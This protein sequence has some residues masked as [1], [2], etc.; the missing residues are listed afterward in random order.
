MD[1]KQMA[2]QALAQARQR[3]GVDE[4]PPVFVTSEERAVFRAI[5]R[6]QEGN[7]KAIITRGYLRLEQVL[8]ARNRYA[9]DVVENDGGQRASEARLKRSDAFYCDKISV[10]VGKRVG[11]ATATFGGYDLHT[12]ANSLT[13]PGAAELA[14]IRTLLNSGRMRIEVDQVIYASQLDLIGMRYVNPAQEGVLSAVGGPYLADGWEREKVLRPMTPTIRFNGG[15]TNLV[16]V[17]CNDTINASAATVTD[18]N[19]LVLLCHGWYAAN[20]AEYNAAARA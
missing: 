4:R 3:A 10:C 6:E 19:V 16:E 9:F 11:F 1:A 12:W 20:C 14:G 5:K 18:E 7:P 17:F 13:F 15:S 8:A 2:Q